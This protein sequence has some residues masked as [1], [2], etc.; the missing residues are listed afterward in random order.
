MDVGNW[1]H[2]LG[3]GLYAAAFVA[4]DIDADVLAKLTAEDL[5]ALGVSSVGHRRK[6][7]TAIAGLRAPRSADGA[8]RR[9]LTVMFCDLVGSTEMSHRFD[10]EDMRVI[11]ATHHKSCAERIAANGGFVAKYMGDGVVAYFGYPQAS[12]QDAENAVRAGLAIAAAG[13][14]QAPADNPLQVRVGIATG[15]VVVGDL[16]G[17]GAAQ[18]RGVVGDTPNLAARL[19]SIAPP[20]GVVLAESTRRLIGDL[21]KLTDLGPQNLKGVAAPQRAFLALGEG[22]LESRYDALRA[23]DLTPI[24]GRQDEIDEL[25]GRWAQ[26][27]GGAGQVVLLSGEAGVGKSRLTAALLERLAKEPYTRQRFFGSPQHTDSALH[28]IVTQIARAIGVKPGDEPTAKLDRLEPTLA[29]AA[30]EPAN[31]ALI[32]ATAVDSQ[33]RSLRAAHIVA[34]R[35]T[36]ANPRSAAGP[37]QRAVARRSAAARLRGRA[38]GR[39]FK[40]RLA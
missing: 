39:S 36:T 37:A 15:V 17:D 2:Q 5:Q 9:Q 12:E 3:L 22:V 16:I 21:F 30:A 40:C 20:D 4:N 31:A 34:A 18:E 24:V 35:S 33:R 26:A 29:G 7:L 1:L 38:L 19:Q 32:A 10:P 14:R 8:E 28:P 23:G 27:R 6:L 13:P 25:L 11:I